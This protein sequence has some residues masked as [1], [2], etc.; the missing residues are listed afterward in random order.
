MCPKVKR[1][2]G[3]EMGMVSGPQNGHNAC[4]EAHSQSEGKV[5]IVLRNIGGPKLEAGLEA[6]SLQLGFLVDVIL[7][8]VS[9]PVLETACL[10][11]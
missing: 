1:Y 7:A 10:G 9:E 8:R 4:L 6:Q 11:G 3:K 2:K 5:K